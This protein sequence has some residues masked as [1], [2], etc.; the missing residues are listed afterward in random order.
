MFI[1]T[2]ISNNLISKF[3]HFKTANR[4]LSSSRT[5]RTCQSPLLREE[6]RHKTQQLHRFERASQAE[7][8][9]LLTS[10]N[11]IDHTFSKTFTQK[12]LRTTTERIKKTQKTKLRNLGLRDRVQLNSNV[13]FNFSSHE[14]TDV[15]SNALAHGL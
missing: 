3:L 15:E 4:H 1:K 13:I 8:Q 7:D 5:Y 11:W 6:L 14:L 9:R 10:N 2:C 12:R